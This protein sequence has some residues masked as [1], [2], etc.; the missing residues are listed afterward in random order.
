MEIAEVTCL[1]GLG[2]PI[3]II[4]HTFQV[5]RNGRT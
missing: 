4:I 3:F 5:K 2:H 1:L